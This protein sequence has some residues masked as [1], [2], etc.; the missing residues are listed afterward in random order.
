[1]ANHFTLQ[2]LTRSDTAVAQRIDNTPPPEAQVKLQRLM[3]KLLDPIREQW[4][5]PIVVNSGYRSPALNR[6]VGGATTS[7]HV[8]GEAADITAGSPAKNKQLFNLILAS[9][10]IFDQLIDEKGYRWLHISLSDSNRTQVL[11]IP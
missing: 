4:G 7:Q 10:L 8:R 5:A 3:D 1:M 2:E 6:A 11:H 9:G